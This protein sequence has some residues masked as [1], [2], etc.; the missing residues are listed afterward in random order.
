MGFGGPKKMVVS[1][2][3]CEPREPGAMILLF[4]TLVF[5]LVEWRELNQ[6][7]RIVKTNKI[8]EKQPAHIWGCHKGRVNI[9]F[10]P[11]SCPLKRALQSCLQS[12]FQACGVSG[13]LPMLM[14][15]LV[16][17]YSSRQGS[18]S[19][20]FV[21]HLCELWFCFLKRGLM[22]CLSLAFNFLGSLC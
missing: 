3:V 2:A 7:Q 9:N 15:F 4:R 1:F 16:F 18:P 21:P 10:P 13:S 17:D 20:E 6:P 22:G 8:T 12:V 5:L 14:E 19:T 11:T